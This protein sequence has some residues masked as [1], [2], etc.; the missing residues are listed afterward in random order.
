ML[1]HK[2]S[3]LVQPF[4][5]HD[6]GP[7]E[8]VSGDGE[9]EVNRAR[10][11]GRNERARCEDA[12]RDCFCT[13]TNHELALDGIFGTRNETRVGDLVQD[14]DF[15]GWCKLL[16]TVR[17]VARVGGQCRDCFPRRRGGRADLDFVGGRNH[18]RLVVGLF[19]DV[20]DQ[21]ARVA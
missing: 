3:T 20:C 4:V 19:G 5:D 11:L 1:S 2:F 7:V 9:R 10:L 16:V 15:P 8:C 18:E 21:K 17:V 6:R 13:F 12:G 14:C